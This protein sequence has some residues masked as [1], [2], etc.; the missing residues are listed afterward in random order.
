MEITH[1]VVNGCS[2]TYCQGLDDPKT[3]GW[4]ALV[5]KELGVPVVNIA[6]PGSG[7]DSIH[8]RT[9]EYVYQNLPT[10]SNPLFLIFWSQ[11]WRREAW[12]EFGFGVKDYRNV[13]V[14]QYRTVEHENA[15]LAHWSEEDFLRRTMLYKLST[16]NLFTANNIPFLMSDY[17]PAFTENMQPGIEHKMLSSINNNPN[18]LISPELYTI[19]RSY[20]ELP[21]GHDGALAQIAIAGW[22]IRHINMRYNGLTF[23]PNPTESFITLDTF[24]IE[25]DSEHVH[26][27]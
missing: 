6:V 9:Y 12:C 10:G 23:S 14:N 19:R 25:K 5:A 17:C 18:H 15:L 1:L 27:K 24:I 20:P 11:Y 21:C 22:W 3:Q 2:W 4:P 13:N 26:W 8:R 7:N 16:I